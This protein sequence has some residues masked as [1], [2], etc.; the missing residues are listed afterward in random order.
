MPTIRFAKSDKEIVVDH[1]DNL[2]FALLASNMPVASSCQGEAVCGKCRVQI[3]EGAENLNEK[4]AG[5]VW[6]AEHN[7]LEKNERIS[8]Q[9]QILGDIK[10]DTKYW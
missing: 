9:T 4:N 3:I 2:M 8:C 10:I 6:L 5:E 1:N 7:N